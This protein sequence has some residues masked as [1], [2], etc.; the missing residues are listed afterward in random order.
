MA[1]TLIEAQNWAELVR[2]CL[3]KVELWCDKKIKKKEML[4][5]DLYSIYSRHMSTLEGPEHPLVNFAI[6]SNNHAL[7]IVP[8]P[9]DHCCMYIQ[10]CNDINMAE[11]A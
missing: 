10:H 6:Q 3:S 8:V 11:A 9:E 7:P 5:T 1:K 4:R 2:Y